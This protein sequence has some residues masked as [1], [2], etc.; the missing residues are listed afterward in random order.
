VLYEFG[1]WKDTKEEDEDTE[2]KDTSTCCTS[3]G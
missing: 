1:R 3:D 2:E